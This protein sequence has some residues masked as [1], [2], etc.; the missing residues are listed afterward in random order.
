MPHPIRAPYTI[1]YGAAYGA[2]RDGGARRHQGCD[3]HCPIGTPIYGTGPGGRVISSVRESGVGIGFGNYVIIAYPGGRQTLDGHMRERSPLPV[4]T[5]VDSSTIVGYVGL[6]G[7]AIYASPPGSHDHHQ[8]T[9]SGTLVDPQSVYGTSTAGDGGTPIPA[10]Q[11]GVDPMSF[12]IIPNPGGNI[13]VQSLI[14]G[15]YASIGSTYHVS[16][17]QRAKKN[18]NNDA[19]NS[20]EQDI[21]HAYLATINPPVTAAP[22]APASPFTPA[23]IAALATAIAQILPAPALH[24]TGT[25]S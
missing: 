15:N 19:M 4:G 20:A 12:S 23:D 3:Y 16:L 1:P 14:T 9:I 21:V 18:D 8:V 13:S 10:I 25:L 2:I 22:P 11:S 6:T 17:L 7:N 24:L 5:A